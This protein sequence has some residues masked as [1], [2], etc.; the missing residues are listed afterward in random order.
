M[1][2]ESFI[3]TNKGKVRPENEDSHA[4]SDRDN[5]WIVCDGMGGSVAGKFASS[6]AAKVIQDRVLSN[7][8]GK[9]LAL[10]EF[11]DQNL[12]FQAL[13]L[14]ESIQL[15]N[16]LL[17]NLGMLYSK[18]QGMGTT[19]CALLIHDNIAYIAH[20]GDSR[21]YLF[22]NTKLHQVTRDHS[23]VMELLEDKEISKKEAVKFKQKN[24]ITRAM[25]V[26]GSCDLDIFIQP[27]TPHTRFFLMC[28]DGLWN[29][30]SENEIEAE[31]QNTSNSPET[32]CRNLI[33]KANAKG[34]PDNITVAAVKIIEHD[35]P[36]INFSNFYEKPIT[37]SNKN[38]AFLKAQDKTLPE[39][40]KDI[41]HMLPPE[42]KKQH[43]REI[44]MNVLLY[45]A[46]SL[47]IIGILL[48]INMRIQLMQ[49][50]P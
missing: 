8:G 38:L 11:Y 9:T 10:D 28:S 39:L 3:L 29:V 36:K 40:I 24:V 22:K 48:L 12:P 33:D 23:F 26:N 2:I 27:V 44:M 14:A 50:N 30:V 34:G 5:L 32:I 13:N 42:I 45:T 17:F 19:V 46:V 43:S 47:I 18:L 15:A 41:K 16:R 1:K 4:F 7:I 31:I 6:V 49:I 25:G 20:V 35:K 37:V 21:L